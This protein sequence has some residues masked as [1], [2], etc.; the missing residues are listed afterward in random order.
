MTRLFS[1][2]YAEHIK[3]TPDPVDAGTKKD[4]NAKVQPESV[5]A[6]RTKQRTVAV[7]G[8]AEDAIAKV[9]SLL[10]NEE[11]HQAGRISEVQIIGVT[12]QGEAE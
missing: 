1:V 9:R 4:P 7:E 8:Y 6:W 11:D 10:V 12:L 2:A 3:F 5:D